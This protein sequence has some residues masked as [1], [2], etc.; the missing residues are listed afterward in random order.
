[1][2]SESTD[3]VTGMACTAFSTS[4][5]SLQPIVEALNRI[6]I[7][8][9]STVDSIRWIF[10]YIRDME[11]ADEQKKRSM[12][13]QEKVSDIHKTFHKDIQNVC[14]YLTNC[15]TGIENMVSTT[16]ELAVKTLKVAEELL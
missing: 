5:S 16:I 12:E 11:K 1:M 6:L 3:A 2:P 15:M 4:I 9:G 13:S 8:D 7:G 10:G 14:N